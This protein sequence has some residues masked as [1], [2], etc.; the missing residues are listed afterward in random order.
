MIRPVVV[1]TGNAHKA[2]EILELLSA[3]APVTLAAVPVPGVGTVIDRADRVVATVAALPEPVEPLDVA[4]TGATLEANALIKARAVAAATGLLTLADDSG[5]EVDALD[6]APGVRS[7]RYAG[8]QSTD[9][10]NVARLLRDLAAVP[11]ERRTARFAAVLVAR[12]PDGREIVVRGE[13][14]GRI[15]AS[16]VGTGG[17]GYDPVFVPTE[18]DGRTFAQMSAEEKHAISHRGR[19]LRALADRLAEEG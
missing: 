18:G 12:E 9:A 17:F 2:R 4:E 15:A 5:L 3:S 8:E 13:V 11:A 1:G 10:D 6:G 14:E 16:P 7:A 19:A